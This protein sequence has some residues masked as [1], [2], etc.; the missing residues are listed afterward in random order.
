MGREPG[1][2]IKLDEERVKG[3]FVLAMKERPFPLKRKGLKMK[4][5]N[6]FEKITYLLIYG[7]MRG[8]GLLPLCVRIGLAKFFARFWF[9][10]DRRHRELAMKNLSMVFPEKS[11]REIRQMAY[12]TFEHWCR[13]AIEIGW[14]LNLDQNNILEHMG[15]VGLEHLAKAYRAGKGV[16]LMTG[17]IGTWELM[18][19]C[20]QKMNV[21]M[22][23]VYRI[24]DFKP[25]DT[26]FHHVRTR[27]G[28]GAIP[29]KKSME[30]IYRELEEGRAIAI[31][32]DQN[33]SLRKGVF[34]DFLGHEACASQGLIRIVM[35]TGTPVVPAFI[36]RDEG[37]DDQ[38][39]LIF[40]PEIPL[41]QTG[42]FEEDIR[43]NT[44]NYNRAIEEMIYRHPT[45]W[46]WM[47]N[48]WKTKRP[49]EDKKSN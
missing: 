46:L 25:L 19:G 30:K 4:N 44:Q 33:A 27:L 17:H 43:I 12:E 11:R 8:L 22:S 9:K 31:L 49:S 38:Y 6:F 1:D 42:D 45:Q 3:H 40:L 20:F 35:Q 23:P 16:F 48:K 47:H 28:G 39:K 36:I 37:R 32:I 21:A 15:F 14:G 18:P 41:V 13:M 29:V 26:F 7:L 24:M 5:M 34:I 2:E 10:V